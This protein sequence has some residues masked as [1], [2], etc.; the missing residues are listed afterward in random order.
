MQRDLRICKP[1]EHLRVRSRYIGE[2]FIGA[3]DDFNRFEDHRQVLKLVGFHLSGDRSGED[4]CHRMDADEEK[5][6]VRG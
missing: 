6:D 4:A 3:L 5:G 1:P 2:G